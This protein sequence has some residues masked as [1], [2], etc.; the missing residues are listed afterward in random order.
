[1]AA[2]LMCGNEFSHNYVSFVITQLGSDQSSTDIV[3]VCL[4]LDIKY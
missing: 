2:I 1:M 3:I 4:L